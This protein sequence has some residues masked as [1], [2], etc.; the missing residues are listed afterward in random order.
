MKSFLKNSVWEKLIGG[1]GVGAYILYK[2][3]IR[4]IH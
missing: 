3:V 2:E 4:L 1:V